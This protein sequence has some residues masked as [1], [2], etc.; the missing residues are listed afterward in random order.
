MLWLSNKHP[1]HITALT[2]TVLHCLVWLIG[3]S[4]FVNNLHYDTIE[5]LYWSKDWLLSYGKHPP[6]VSWIVALATPE[7]YVPILNLLLLSQICVGFSAYFIWKSAR[8]YLPAHLALYAIMIYLLS[9]QANHFSLQFNHNALLMPFWSATLY[10]G[11]RFIIKQDIVSGLWSGLVA[12]LSI[13]VKYQ[14]ILILLSVLL[15]AFS[16]PSRRT[17]FKTPGFWLGL[18]LAGLLVLPHVIWLASDHW[19]VLDYAAHARKL[20]G[21]ETYSAG[22]T[23][24][25]QAAGNILVGEGVLVIGPLVF[26]GLSRVLFGLRFGLERKH[27]LLVLILFAGPTIL[28]VAGVF[29]TGQIPKQSWSLVFMPNVALA[30]AL[31]LK[32]LN[33][34]WSEGRSG[35]WGW[36]IPVIALSLSLVQ[37]S[38]FVGFILLHDQSKSPVIT[39]ELKA[40]VL[41]EKINALWTGY[42]GHDL[43]CLVINDPMIPGSALL[44]MK[45]RP[46][47][48]DFSSPYWAKPERIAQC[49]RRG[50]I[51]ALTPDHPRDSVLAA[52]PEACIERAQRV[53]IPTRFGGMSNAQ[54][55]DLLII[56]PVQ[57][58]ARCPGG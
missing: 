23:A 38:I 22:F 41:A 16:G 42:D 17:L 32:P 57:S 3:S 21:V 28:L 24:F 51:A 30:S 1:Y 26:M 20:S 18:G 33:K 40:Q 34:G 39:Y 47:V 14:E 27:L 54:P 29:A 35:R 37:F 58:S 10:T 25:I 31:A 12:G 52:F 43:P 4:I 55:V 13:L 11:L 15:V 2:I 8:L 49:L 19:S 9:P 7:G 5:I 6:L 44:W 56:P 45:R 48:V 50:G 53:Y 36:P 46:D